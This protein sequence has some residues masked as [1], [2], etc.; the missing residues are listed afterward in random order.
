LQR[1]KEGNEN[2]YL[3][4]VVFWIWILRGKARPTVQK[5]IFSISDN[6]I[7]VDAW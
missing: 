6:C 5:G 3:L 2:V 1:A 4:S 7:R